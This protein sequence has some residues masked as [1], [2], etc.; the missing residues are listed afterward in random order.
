MKSALNR[1]LNIMLL[2]LP[3]AGCEALQS[4]ASRIIWLVL[5]PLAIIVWLL[6]RLAS[7]K[8][9]TPRIKRD[10]RVPDDDD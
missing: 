2:S 3:L 1:L 8:G 4:G 10:R 5:V 7:R 6:W 9:Q